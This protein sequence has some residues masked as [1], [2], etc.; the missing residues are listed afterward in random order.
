MNLWPMS[1]LIVAVSRYRFDYT[2]E[3]NRPMLIIKNSRLYQKSTIAV[4]LQR[5]LWLALALMLTLHVL[6]DR[7]WALEFD[8]GP[9][10]TTP[11]AVWPAD[12]TASFPYNP[13]AKTGSL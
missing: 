11:E 9:P 10:G 2:P 1:I 5:V 12:C 6:P 7:L 3:R 13:E 4:I 8:S